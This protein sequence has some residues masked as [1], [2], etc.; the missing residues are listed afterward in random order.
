MLVDPVRH[1]RADDVLV[2]PRL[3]TG[4]ATH[5]AEVFQ[6]SITSWSSKIMALGTTEITHRST[7]S[8]HDSW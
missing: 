3:G 6:S 2:P 8:R 5:A 7:S 4:L 1:H